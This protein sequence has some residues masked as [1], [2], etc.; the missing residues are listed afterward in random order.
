MGRLLGKQSLRRIYHG[1]AEQVVLDAPLRTARVEVRTED[2]AE[3]RL[4]TGQ[5]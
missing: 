3:K 2:G 1:C 5:G 4:S